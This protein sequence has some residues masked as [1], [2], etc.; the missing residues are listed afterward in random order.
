M[1][2]LY[3]PFQ[4]NLLLLLLILQSLDLLAAELLIRILILL[5]PEARH[6][7]FGCGRAE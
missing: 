6:L 4:R 2:S 1:V 7:A 3:K 5:L